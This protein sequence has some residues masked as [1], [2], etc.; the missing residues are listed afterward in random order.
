PQPAPQQHVCP[1]CHT[2]LA[3]HARFCPRCGTCVEAGET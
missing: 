3:A 1:G 2:E